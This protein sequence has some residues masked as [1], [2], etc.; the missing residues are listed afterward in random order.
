MQ[1]R[2][3][4]LRT[5]EIEVDGRSIYDELNHKSAALLFYLAASGKKLLSR[6][7]LS[8]LL[9]PNQLGDSARSNLRQ[10]LSAV[11]KVCVERL[12]LSDS[13]IESYKEGCRLTSTGSV[14]VDVQY[15]NEML[16]LARAD[17][18]EADKARHLREAVDCYHSAF[19]E[20]FYVKGSAAF[21]EW[22]LYERDT[23][24]RL[25]AEA[26]KKLS[27]LCVRRDRAP[28]AIE[29]MT[30]LLKLDTLREDVYQELMGLYLRCGDRPGAIAIY[31]KCEK[32]LREELNIGPMKETRRLYE[33]AISQERTP[34]PP[35]PERSA[36]ASTRLILSDKQAED[37]SA[38]MNAGFPPAG[39]VLTVGPNP[40]GMLAYEGMYCLLEQLLEAYVLPEPMQSAAAVFFPERGTADAPA[41][42][43]GAS[44]IYLFSLFKA[45]LLAC[46]AGR[47]TALVFRDPENLDPKTQ[48][49]LRYLWWNLDSPDICLAAVGSSD[50]E[51]T[52]LLSQLRATIPERFSGVKIMKEEVSHGNDL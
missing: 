49:L 27:A 45:I 40:L 2:F 38:A 29:H 36:A 43:G 25:F 17:E 13:I 4:L 46:T 26:C 22:I 42:V 39:R 48:A 47:R 9:W 31:Q 35:P 8:E 51:R 34:A 24:N 3:Y 19:L 44:D 6:D 52:Q 28:Q 30:K 20:G 37:V 18:T 23:L 21:E 5:P 14:W 32:A 50:G 41:Y 15:F 11:K 10:T 1:I 33:Q 16:A 7:E 12:G